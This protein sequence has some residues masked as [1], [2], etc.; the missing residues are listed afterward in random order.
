MRIILYTGKGGVGKTSVAAATALRTAELGHRTLVLS[1]DAAHSLADSFD[2]PLAGEPQEVAP[3]LWAQ[4]T[5]VTQAVES[6]W[7]TVQRWMATLMAWRGL[8]EIVASEMAVLPGMDELANLLY[9]LDYYDKGDYDV[10]IV[11]C[12][13]TGETLR[14]L[15]FPE[16]L[17]W[18]VDKILP[19]ERRAAGI[20]RPMVRPFVNIPLPGDEVFDSVQEIFHQLERMHSLLTNS[21]EASVRLVVNPEKMVIKEAQRTF[22]YLNL[23]GYATDLVVCNR[24]IPDQ[25][26]D[27]YFDSWKESQSRHRQAIEERFSPIPIRNIPLFGNEVVGIPMLRLMAQSLFGD[28]DPAQV[29]FQGLAHAVQKEDSHYTLSLA[30]PFTTKQDISLAQNGDELTVQVGGYRRNII[31]PRTLLGLPVTGA[32]FEDG[33]LKIRFEL[34][35]KTRP[36]GKKREKR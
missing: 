36:A 34:D 9:I 31:L 30:L 20:L 10:L 18:W 33:R 7:G 25:V 13:P 3:N 17:R 22:T 35:R 2:L 23:Y 15:S 14:L 19:L 6:H 1:T 27:S 29:F 21:Q 4:E 28:E 32:R 16:V 12:A 26:S 5:E 8:E 24:L 11:D